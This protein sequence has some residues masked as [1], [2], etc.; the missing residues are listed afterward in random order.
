LF[1]GAL[2]RWH[3]YKGLDVLIRAVSLLK[4]ESFRVRLLIVGGGELVSKYIQLS[5][6]LRIRDQVVFAGDVSDEDLPTYYAASDSL[7]L[8][9]TDRCEG[10]GL[11]ILEA[12]ATGKPL[13]CNRPLVRYG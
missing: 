7:V 13:V 4:A 5:V 11:V 3:T 9:S 8:P 2:T 10:F 1:V 6:N 12:N